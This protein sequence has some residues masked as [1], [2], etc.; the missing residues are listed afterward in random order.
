MPLASQ[1][2]VLA[3]GLDILFDAKLAPTTTPDSAKAWAKAYT[4]YAVSAGI[5]LASSK[6][7]AL[8]GGLTAA[9]N[10]TLAGGGP[11]LFI[12]ALGLFWVGLIIPYIASNP[13]M[14]ATALPLAP[15][16]SVTPPPQPEDATTQQK[17]D[18]LAATIAAFTLGSVKVLVPALPGAPV[19]I[20]IY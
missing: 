9:F 11:P 18:T 10:P 20:P 3:R 5:P 16:G 14:T 4:A 1:T 7:D 13:P 12:Q 17:A 2:S 19:T 6:E 8:A 15:S